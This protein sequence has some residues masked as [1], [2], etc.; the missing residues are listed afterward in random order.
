[1][2]ASLL[3]SLTGVD[4]LYLGIASEED[5]ETGETR[6]VYYPKGLLSWCDEWGPINASK[7][8]CCHDIT[9]TGTR[10]SILLRKLAAGNGMLL[11]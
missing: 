6:G 1:L 3:C 10:A 4:A 5:I 8:D 2:N 11:A 9:K 7:I